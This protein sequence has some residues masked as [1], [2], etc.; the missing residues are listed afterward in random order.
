[1]E[2]IVWQNGSIE[3]PPHE[4]K[5]VWILWGAHHEGEK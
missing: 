1:M 5:R 4:P 3:S 2:Y